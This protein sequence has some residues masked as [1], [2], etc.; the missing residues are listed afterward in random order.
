[1][2]MLHSLDLFTGIGGFALA[3]HDVATTEAY[4]DNSENAQKIIQARIMEGKLHDAPIIDDVRA[5]TR[6][7]S[8]DLKKINLI[9][10]GFP[11]QDVSNVG[12]NDSSRS[13]TSGLVKERTGLV[14]EVMRLTA[15]IKPSFVFLENVKAITR[16]PAFSSMLRGFAQLGYRGY[17]DQFNAATIGFPHR[18]DRWFMLA[19]RD[20]AIALKLSKNVMKELEQVS[21]K[22]L[23]VDRKEQ[24]LM[25][26]PPRGSDKIRVRLELLGNSL[27]PDVAR[28]AFR[29]LLT[30]SLKADHNQKD[31]AGGTGSLVAGAFYANGRIATRPANALER[32][33]PNHGKPLKF[34]PDAD[35]TKWR[36]GGGRDSVRPKLTDGAQKAQWST[37]RHGVRLGV[38]SI[39]A[40]TQNDLPVQLIYWENTPQR[41]RDKALASPYEASASPRFVENMMGYPRDWTLL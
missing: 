16:D 37:P 13:G 10:A 4:C 39:T 5:I 41:L 15:Q 11:C 7:T 22:P 36:S 2:P 17:W 9:C 18:R 29:S 40:R 31:P 12:I 27:V 19:V 25:A 28:L 8:I 24:P 26:H 35:V 21:Q 1:M 14:V 32:I 6:H 23:H 33:S 30:Q 20:D 38:K 34:L 3:L